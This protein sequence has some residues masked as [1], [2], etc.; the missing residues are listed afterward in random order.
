MGKKDQVSSSKLIKDG[1]EMALKLDAQNDLAWN[2]LGRWHRNIASMGTV[3]KALAAMI[4]EKLPSGSN[5]EAV[6]CLQKAIK[7]NPNRLM[8]YVE[9]GRA[10]AQ[11]GNYDDAKRY[12]EKG[13]SMPC[14]D[15]DDPGM[16][17]TA[18]EVL[19]SIR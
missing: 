7:I 3:T 9:L 11:M 1:A 14:V 19:A 4:Y 10:Y 18:R 13:L 17:E 6:N 15:K 8:H 5:E 16:K 2:I 12:L